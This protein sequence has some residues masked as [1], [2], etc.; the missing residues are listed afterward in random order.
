MAANTAGTTINIGSGG[1]TMSGATLRFGWTSP[2]L[3]SPSTARVNLSGNF[4]GSGLE[5]NLDTLPGLT[6]ALSYYVDISA[7]GRVDLAVVSVPE[8]G[9]F[10]LL[11]LGLLALSPSARRFRR[12]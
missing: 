9:S 5:V 8:P 6:S 12:S 10:L 4:T 2:V 11:A 3:S 7:L 1:L